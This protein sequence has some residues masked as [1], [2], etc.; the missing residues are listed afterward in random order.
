MARRACRGYRHSVE[1]GVNFVYY[2]DELMVHPVEGL[3]A[4]P[5][6]SGTSF[7]FQKSCAMKLGDTSCNERGCKVPIP[8][9]PGGSKK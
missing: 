2:Y 7:G 5:T 9:P 4:N 3:H 1:N 6:S 8:R